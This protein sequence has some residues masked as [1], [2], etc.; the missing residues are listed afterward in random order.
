V[1]AFHLSVERAFWSWWMLI[2]WSALASLLAFPFLKGLPIG[3]LPVLIGIG[4]AVGLKHI[5]SPWIAFL[6]KLIYG[7]EGQ[8]WIIAVSVLGLLL[9]L[10]IILFPPIPYIDHALYYNAA[11]RLASGQGFTEEF[12]LYPPG[13][14]AWL[15]IWV[16]V[17]GDNLRVLALVQSAL[18]IASI[19]LLYRT[20][21]PYSE[22]AARWACLIVAIFPS[23]VLWSGTLGHETTGIF[24]QIAVMAAFLSALRVRGFRAFFAWGA[25][26][27][28]GGIAALVRPTFLA[29][30]ALIGLTM[31]VGGTN[32]RRILFAV[33]TGV[34]FMAIIIAP[35]S[36]RNYRMFGEVCIV[37]ANFGSVLLSANHPNSDGVFMQTE[38]IGADLNPIA[39]DRLKNKLAWDAIQEDPLR[40]FAR[41]VK[42]IV[43]TWGT[44]SS[45]LENVL[46]DP[47]R[48][49]F[50]VKM[51]LSAVLNVVWSWF[52]CAWC[53]DST[54][55]TPWRST[56]S[57]VEIW[58]AC[59]VMLVWA[60]H[61]VLE[62][63]SRHHL[64]LLPIMGL[65][66]LP[67]YWS[68]VA[69]ERIVTDSYVKI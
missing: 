30:P 34:V 60:V 53:I 46:G 27:G 32:I 49:G 63:L 2:S 25:L 48:G 15:A 61:A 35:W 16:F 24:L 41:S 6:S 9:R 28:L 1:G 11:R 20:V 33:A 59:W 68:W 10:P 54:Y 14:S 67:G 56:H 50:I 21:K 38:G 8:S 13:Q 66:F 45:I 23:L 40:F 52:V 58:P 29:L 19:F 4:L 43:I 3:I 65:I 47:P 12:I 17:L 37:S 64:S 57:S 39:R 55:R 7:G 36:I 22:E 18:S 44:D 51:G 5:P 42:R 26:G 69:R 31:W 62:P